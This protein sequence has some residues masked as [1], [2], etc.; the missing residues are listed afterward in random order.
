MNDLPVR[1]AKACVH[2]GSLVEQREI[3]LLHGVELH[4]GAVVACAGRVIGWGGDESLVGTLTLHLV[5]NATLGGHDKLIGI[6][7]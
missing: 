6:G 4:V 2:L 5:Q 3:E 1:R 7:L